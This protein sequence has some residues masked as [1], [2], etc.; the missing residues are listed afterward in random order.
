M[1]DNSRLLWE[2]L[3][4]L[5]RRLE[6]GRYWTD[7][8]EASQ[9]L[10]AAGQQIL[11]RLKKAAGDSDPDVAHWAQQALDQFSK[12]MRL[13]PEET[14]EKMERMLAEG[15]EPTAGGEE[16]VEPARQTKQ[17]PQTADEMIQWLEDYAGRI[18]G[19]FG[20][21]G[22]G[23]T[24][25]LPAGEGRRQTLYFDLSGA[26]RQG[27]PVALIYSVSGRATAETF[28]WALEEN[29]KLTRGAFGLINH[30]GRDVLIMLM[31]RPLDHLF[32]DDLP[33]QLD[34]LAR[35]AD[36]AEARLGETDRH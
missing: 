23:A 9:Q 36:E 21:R 4:G 13:K 15:E 35:K 33:K 34:Y 3:R 5:I 30:K 7:R 32:Y 16:A 28:R 14:A 19:T 18:G 25:E 11:Y 2:G 1:K 12:D 22:E 17:A 26:D 6:D 8:R 20:R 10:L 29:L 31:R 27:K 24:L